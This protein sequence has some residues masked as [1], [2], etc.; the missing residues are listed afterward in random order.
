[1]ISNDYDVYQEI[2]HAVANLPQLSVNFVHIKGH[3]NWN[4][5]KWPLTLLAWLNIERDKHATRFL[6]QPAALKCMTT[7]HYQT[8]TLM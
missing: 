5:Q 1:M 3:Q 2:A 4:T 7:L 6:C 8:P